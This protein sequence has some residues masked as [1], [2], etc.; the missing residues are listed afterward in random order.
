MAHAQET[1]VVL[2]LCCVPFDQ[3][4]LITLE[5]FRSYQSEI[6]TVKPTELQAGSIR[7]RAKKRRSISWGSVPSGAAGAPVTSSHF[8]NRA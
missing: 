3:T 5:H 8:G 6:S 7:H 2:V 4:R 1:A